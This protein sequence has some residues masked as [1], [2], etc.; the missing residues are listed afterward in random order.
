M[1]MGNALTSH[2]SVHLTL[3]SVQQGGTLIMK[4]Y[5]KCKLL[6]KNLSF[7]YEAEIVNSFQSVP[8]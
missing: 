2:L 5:I 8:E 4:N 7:Y 1:G 3:C 6:L